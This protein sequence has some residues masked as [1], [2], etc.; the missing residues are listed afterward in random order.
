MSIMKKALA[1]TA[2]TAGAVALVAAPAQAEELIVDGS[3]A[4]YGDCDLDGA[5]GSFQAGG[6]ELRGQDGW[7]Y[8]CDQGADGRFY[9]TIFR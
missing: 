2:L 6:V 1:A 7:L 3:Y 9:M 5:S 4:T 8:R